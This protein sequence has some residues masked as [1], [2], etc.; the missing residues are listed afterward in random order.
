M[1]Q[2]TTRAFGAPSRYIQ[3]PGE[4]KN[5]VTH[6]SVYGTKVLALIDPFFFD[7]F[8]GL[9]NEMY[10]ETDSTIET[11]KFNGEASTNEIERVT[12][13]ADG[14]GIDVVVGIGGGKT[15]DT[16]KAVSDK[17]G[18]TMIVSPTAASSDA[19]CSALSVVYTDE[20]QHSHEL[21]YKKNPDVVL[22]DSEIVANAPVRLLVSGMG[23]ALA[24]YFEA[25]ANAESNSA[26]YVGAGYKRTRA[27]MAIARL[28]YDTMLEFGLQAK[29][30]VEAKVVTPALE[31]I[32]ESN[33][34]LSGLGFESTGCA[35]A[36]GIHDALT[37]L[38]Q[39]AKYYHGEKVAFGTLCQ[40]V[41]EQRPQE[42]VMEVMNFCKS[43]GL[44]TTLAEVGLAEVTE[45]ELRLVADEAAESFLLKAEPFVATSDMILAAI[46]TTDALGKHFA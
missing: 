10:K 35:G 29:L 7:S 16:A 41:L 13:L 25:R 33:T 37:A 45:E 5:L 22:L 42:E 6:T 14:K 18:A 28:S 11:V 23:D 43:V 44:P 15:L 12:E 17:L 38:P 3:G 9:F 26:N 2:T 46:K 34:L 4:L 24:T 8:T 30:A 27:A 21:Y 36:H 20:G 31:D 32:I 39:T 19:P 40:L 1:I